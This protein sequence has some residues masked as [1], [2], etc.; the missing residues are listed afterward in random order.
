MVN[1]ITKQEEIKQQEKYVLHSFGVHK[2]ATP[3]QKEAAE[4]IAARSRE[5]I[6]NR[7]RR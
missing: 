3:E 2:N 4:I 1:I 5:V 7:K 6:N